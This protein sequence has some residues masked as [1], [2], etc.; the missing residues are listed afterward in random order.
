MQVDQAEPR[1]MR[2]W[3]FDQQVA[4][5]RV[6]VRDA[7]VVRVREEPPER[8]GEP[9]V[10][11]VYKDMTAIPDAAY[12]RIGKRPPGGSADERAET[13]VEPNLG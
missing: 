6:G 10:H 11:H 1:D 12:V 4:G 13:V 2:C 7:G 9:C 5:V 8:A 3:K